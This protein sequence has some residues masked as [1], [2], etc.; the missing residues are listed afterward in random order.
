M[1]KLI[2]LIHV[3]VDGRA[4]SLKSYI[5]TRLLAPWAGNLN[6]SLLFPLILIV[7][8]IGIMAPLYRNKIFIK[9]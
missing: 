1:A 9:I 5:F 2:D 6:G 8:W 3:S 7:L 4:L